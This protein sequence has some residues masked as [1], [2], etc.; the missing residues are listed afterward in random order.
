M[1]GAAAPL[2]HEG[3]EG[4]VAIPL[5]CHCEAF[6]RS[7]ERRS[8]LNPRPAGRRWLWG[9]LAQPGSPYQFNPDVILR[10]TRAGLETPAYGPAEAGSGL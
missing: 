9:G 8:N 1:A 4:A 10:P 3:C 5:T 6:V 2:E 7:T